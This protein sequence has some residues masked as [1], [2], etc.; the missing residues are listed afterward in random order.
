MDKNTQRDNSKVMN[1]NDSKIQKNMKGEEGDADAAGGG[2]QSSVASSVF[3][4]PAF[5]LSK[6]EGIDKANTNTTGIDKEESANSEGG[7]N[8]H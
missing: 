4:R 6:N 3:N 7:E 2:S 1:D 8:Q 5:V